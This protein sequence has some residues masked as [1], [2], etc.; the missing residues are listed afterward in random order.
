MAGKRSPKDQVMALI[1]DLGMPMSRADYIE[2]C[3]EISS[4][5]DGRAQASRE[6]Q[7]RDGE[8]NDG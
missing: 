6:D 7:E 5:C 3:E 8:N 4:D 1:D 2:F